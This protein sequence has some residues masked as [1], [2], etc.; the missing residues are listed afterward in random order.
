MVF[1]NRATE[2]M[3]GRAREAMLGAPITTLMPE[4]YRRAHEEGIARVEAGGETHVIGRVIELSGLRGEQEFP[5]EL[6]LSRWEGAHGKRF[7]TGVVRDVTE[8]SRTTAAL[9]DAEVQL[10]LTFDKAAIGVALVA[11]DGSWLR[12]NDA[13]C[14]LLGYTREALLATHFQ[15]ITHPDDLAKD[16]AEVELLLAGKTSSYQLEKRYLHRQGQIVWVLLTVTL[17][18]DDAGRPAFFVAQLQD[19]TERKALE[20]Q[21]HQASLVDE[22]TCLQNRRGF[23]MLG[24]QQLQTAARYGRPLIVVF[25]DLNG[26]KQINDEQGHEVGDRALCDM[27]AVLRTTFRRA[28]ILARLGGDEFVVLAEGGTNFA[29]LV[30]KR[31]EENVEHHNRSMGRP[32]AL[33]VS[34]GVA[35]YEP[36]RRVTLA[37]LLAR[38]DQLMYDEKRAKRDSTRATR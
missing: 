1:C 21:L 37:E 2:T 3:F 38:A 27:A 19:V 7:Y 26:M 24:E 5:L 9:R 20:E 31:L 13:V 35:I 12:V 15:H 22:L 14:N 34:I 29:R 28:D 25:A 16:V 10:R 8:R 4:R 17:V 11:P 33:S 30:R 6:S 36:D 23:L 32:Y 18:R